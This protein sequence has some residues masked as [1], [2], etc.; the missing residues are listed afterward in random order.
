MPDS[1]RGEVARL[2]SDRRHGEWNNDA[3]TPEAIAEAEQRLAIN[4]AERPDSTVVLAEFAL[5]VLDR[6][7]VVEPYEG[8]GARR[9]V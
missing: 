7:G 1:Q 3:W 5:R 4:D 2:R 6:L 9:D 8:P